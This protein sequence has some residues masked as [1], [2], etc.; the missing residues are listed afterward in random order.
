MT[1]KILKIDRAVSI[2][3]ITDETI[4][5]EGWGVIFGDEDLYGDEFKSE[6]DFMLDLVPEKLTLYDHTL[7][8]VKNIIGTVTSVEMKKN[9][10]IGGLWVEAEL[11]RSE[12]Y[13]EQV[14]E[15]LEKGV[16]GWSSGS[17]P[18]LVERAGSFV[19]RWPIVEFS[20][21]PT[22]A[23]PR[24][25]GVDVLKVLAEH[26]PE[27]KALLKASGDASKANERAATKKLY[28]IT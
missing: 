28:I 8:A 24:T 11:D 9:G 14:V 13:V 3:A 26:N 6:T 4:T 22:P 15:L 17:V 7:G 19:K 1:D 27:F 23:E 16:L 10:D 20:L 21:T 12:A 25:L 18:H 2:K 5:V